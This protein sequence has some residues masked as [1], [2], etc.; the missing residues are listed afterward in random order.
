MAI[1]VHAVGGPAYLR[2]VL[3]PFMLCV[4]SRK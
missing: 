3:L 2:A 4:G 1:E